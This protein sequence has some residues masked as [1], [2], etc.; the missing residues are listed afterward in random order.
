MKSGVLGRLVGRFSLRFYRALSFYLS[1]GVLLCTIE[2]QAAVIPSAED[3]AML[4]LQALAKIKITAAS[5]FQ[6]DEL[7]TPASVTIIREQD[8]LRTGARN[9][10]DAFQQRASIYSVPWV[11]AAQGVAIRG[12]PPSGRSGVLITLDDVPIPDFVS[13]NAFQRL[14]SL[15]LGSLSS[16]QVVRGP[17]SALHGS[18]A[19]HGVI[20]LR[21]FAANE[22]EASVSGLAA[23]NGYYQ[24]TARLSTQL[25]DLGRFNVALA[26]NG[27][28]DQ[29]VSY[30][31]RDATGATQFGERDNSYGA[32]SLAVAFDSDVNESWSYVVGA[33]AHRYDAKGFDAG[34]LARGDRAVSDA[35]AEFYLARL[36][37]TKRFATGGSL[38]VGSYYWTLDTDDSRFNNM[39]GVFT[40]L[41]LPVKQHRA[42]IRAIYRDQ[43][44]D[45]T[46]MAVVLGITEHKVD[47]AEAIVA[48]ASGVVLSRVQQLYAGAKRTGKFLT[49][50]G[51]TDFDDRRFSF[52]YG[53]RF[54]T[55]SDAANQLSPRLGLIYHPQLDTAIKLLYGHGFR[56][57]VAIETYG[58]VGI[59]QDNP[60]LKPE[61]FDS[62]ELVWL[63][64]TAR[65]R[66]QLNAFHS[67]WRDGIDTVVHPTQPATVRAENLAKTTADGVEAEYQLQLG[68]WSLRSDATYIKTD[69]DATGSFTTIPKWVGTLGL[70]Y[71]LPKM[72]SELWLTQ[73]VQSAVDDV[74][75]GI[76]FAPTQLPV[77]WRADAYAST[78]C[79][80]N[81]KLW[82]SVRNIFDRGN[83]VPTSPAAQFGL[84]DDALSVGLGVGY[85][86]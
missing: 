8:W 69:N 72:R 41:I 78:R 34:T 42:G 28:P 16:I 74:G 37:L 49:F 7:N 57:P 71:A 48:S 75:N 51:N 36:G 55:Y 3:L 44:S 23:S 9:L 79:A 62:V 86:F 76:L 14:P 43:W 2:S 83:R 4:P 27:Q 1:V 77:Y 6:N 21:S 66:L 46:Q 80:E 70:G 64:Q 56:A 18:D 38:N 67:V 30:E 33:Y 81:L 31:F 45:H 52:T 68:A 60:D 19:F 32:Q 65:W 12:L 47:A 63:R 24:S 13:G 11:F 54:D 17:G 82:L 10:T 53:A 35:M 26:V 29:N 15:N 39:A 85:N 40:T 5:L 84:A 58:A 22:D 73:R 20:S 25:G 59:I 61:T 50:E